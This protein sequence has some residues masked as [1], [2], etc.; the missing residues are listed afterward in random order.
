MV[1]MSWERDVDGKWVK[2]ANLITM[3]PPVG[4]LVELQEEPM[5]GSKFMT[6]C[7]PRGNKTQVVVAGEWTSKMIPPAQLEKAVMA[8]L[9]KTY[10]EDVA[11]LKTFTARR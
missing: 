8:N 4:F 11:G 10:D 3:H 7:V 2:M 9:G 5:A 1:L 6:Y